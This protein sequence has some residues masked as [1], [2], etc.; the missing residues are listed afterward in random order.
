VKKITEI[1]ENPIK[2]HFRGRKHPRTHRPTIAEIVV[3]RET[4]K[5]TQAECIDNRIFSGAKEAAQ[6][7]IR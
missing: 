5:P 6:N 7:K 2:C 4:S 1:A 3:K